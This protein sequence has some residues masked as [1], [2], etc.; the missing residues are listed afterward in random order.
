MPALRVGTHAIVIS[1][2]N[3]WSPLGRA[4]DRWC[5]RVTRQL[6]IT[7]GFSRDTLDKCHAGRKNE[8]NEAII[9]P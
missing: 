8:R 9:F 5:S 3:L 1:S 6:G 7:L 2:L 4:I